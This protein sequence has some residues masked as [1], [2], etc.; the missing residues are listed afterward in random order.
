MRTRLRRLGAAALVVLLS[1]AIASGSAQ[2]T[3]DEEIDSKVQAFLDSHKY[4]W[5][6]ENVAGEDG[7]VLFDL[8]V[9]NKYTRAL[10]VG[11][12]TGHSAIWIAW[13]LSKT[14]GRLITVE[15]D[16][17]RHEKALENFKKAGLS[18]FIDARLADAH[19][20]VPQLEGSFD[21]VFIDADKNWYTNYAKAILP[22][23]EVGGCLTARNVRNLFY[24][25]GIREFLDYVQNEPELETRIDEE[26]RSGISI[27]YKRELIK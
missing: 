13:A 2:T 16:E 22:K 21:F 5:R 17:Y 20:L 11:T 3:Q 6:Y 8:I 15:I 24:M 18:E 4:Q 26:S 19:E 14:G 9:E 12:S 27:S 10:E 23:L 1:Q 7:K 25:R